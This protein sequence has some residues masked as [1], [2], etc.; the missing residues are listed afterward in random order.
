M[1]DYIYI[2]IHI[3][4]EEFINYASAPVAKKDAAV[5][6]EWDWPM[7]LAGLKIETQQH[8]S[9]TKRVSVFLYFYPNGCRRCKSVERKSRYKI[10]HDTM[11]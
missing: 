8:K 4:E 7:K 3:F 6:Y 9:T 5:Q 10:R 11:F 1:L 2:Y